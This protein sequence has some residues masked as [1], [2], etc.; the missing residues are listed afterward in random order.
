[1]SLKTADDISKTITDSLA[2]LS[3]ES[4]GNVSAAYC[5]GY[6]KSY[7]ASFVAGLPGKYRNEFIYDL[8]NMAVNNNG[9]D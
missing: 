9:A 4:T 6:F 7:V 2:A 8:K 3:I 1:M 5:H